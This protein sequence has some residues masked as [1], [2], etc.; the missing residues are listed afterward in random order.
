MTFYP[1]IVLVL[2]GVAAYV[3]VESLTL[4]AVSRK[5]LYAWIGLLG[6][7]T[8]TYCVVSFQMYSSTSA[9]EGAR[10]QF[11]QL[12]IS[13][14]MV[15]VAILLGLEYAGSLRRIH[16]IGLAVLTSVTTVPMWIDG[17]GLSDRP[18]IKE[19]PWL[20]VRYY[21]AELGPAPIVFF[22]VGVLWM[23]YVA[24]LLVRRA[25]RGSLRDRLMCVVYI[26]WWVA[27][28]NDTMVSA[29]V[30]QGPYVVE[31]AFFLII[32]VVASMAMTAQHREG[33]LAERARQRLAVEVVAK[34]RDLAFAQA[35]LTEAAK[36][37]AVGR[38]AAGVAHEVNNPLAYVMANL[39]LLEQ[40]LGGKAELLD[41]TRESL[42]GARRIQ[43][44]VRQLFG[45]SRT[46]PTAVGWC[47]PA[48]AADAAVKMSMVELGDRAL[49]EVKL[50][51][52]PYVQMDEGQLAQV[53]LNLLVNAAQS[54]APG[55][56][57][58]NR[59]II[60][61]RAIDG[62]V[63]ISVTD[64]GVG[65]P[66]SV[67]PQI[68]EPFFST[69]KLQDGQGLGLAISRDLVRKAGG[70]IVAENVAP[71][72]AR[73]QVRLP[74]ALATAS[75]GPQS[76]GAAPGSDAAVERAA[77]ARLRL[78][79][80]DDEEPLR[81]AL[82]RLI[83]RS[84]DVQA[85]DS[86]QAA[87]ACLEAGQDFDVILCDMMMPKVSGPE[88]IHRIREKNPAMLHRTILM[89]GGVSNQKQRHVDGDMSFP[90]LAKPF[91]LAELNAAIGRLRD[92]LG[93]KK[94]P[95]T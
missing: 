15:D 39:Q 26:F 10:W 4:Y 74:I 91:N 42:D 88:V 20:G 81:R 70:Q 30:Y 27:G 53:L 69:K 2:G 75:H 58:E 56:R 71:H 80:V 24:T 57:D 13:A 35:E 21:E 59:V 36:L 44:V 62:Q 46:A 11:W 12:V 68:F 78:L 54:I 66:E 16:V 85:V 50:P 84:Y 3:G 9:A 61:A 41:L 55:K 22:V 72:G 18:A 87:L 67:L 40:E 49:L 5:R 33:Q 79:L 89:T 95:G 25:L 93:P 1:G 47:D 6:M 45:F 34:D 90:V 32:V 73:L 43:A 64:T 60:E 23:G 63:E 48:V 19:I 29:G 51:A 86:G 37:A 31:F 65:I 92:G 94:V 83:E 82:S 28:A 52:L 76:A 7:I 77:P 38:L 8:G 14:I 17:L